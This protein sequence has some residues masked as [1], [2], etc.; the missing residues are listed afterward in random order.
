MNRSVGFDR[1]LYM[2]PFDQRESF[3]TKLF[4][5]KGK[6][7]DAQTREIAVAKQV[8]YDGFRAAIADG[9]PKE[10]AAILVDEQFGADILRDARDCGFITTSPTER[11][12]QK[13]FELEYGKDFARHI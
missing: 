1:L 10:A 4:G 12:G 3:Q 9:A 6:L 7:T 2:L 11:S 8:I 13:E 5:W